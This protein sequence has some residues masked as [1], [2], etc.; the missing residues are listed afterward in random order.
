MADVKKLVKDRIVDRLNRNPEIA[1][2]LGVLVG[3]NI[4]G[5]GGGAWIIDCTEHPVTSHE[6]DERKAAVSIEMSSEDFSKL[7]TGELNAVSAFMFGK[8]KVDGD[9][10]KAVAL[11]R[12]IK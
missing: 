8:I 10:Q 5:E 3:V 11:G 7:S 9:I 1:D 4:T 2:D 6:D 12:L